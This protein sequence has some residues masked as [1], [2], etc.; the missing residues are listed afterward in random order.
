MCFNF[1]SFKHN[2]YKW[3]YHFKRFFLLLHNGLINLPNRNFRSQC[4][5]CCS[6]IGVCIQ[7]QLLWLGAVR[8]LHHLPGWFSSRCESDLHSHCP[9]LTAPLA[10]R[11]CG[12]RL[13]EQRLRIV[14]GC[15][16]AFH[17]FLFYQVIKAAVGQV[18]AVAQGNLAAE[19]L[20]RAK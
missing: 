3:V 11:K 1:F 18:G 13:S 9:I 5:Q 7:C 14:A 16:V 8:R 6:S 15:H 17:C 19:D 2:A 12:A 20:N 4:N 10:Y